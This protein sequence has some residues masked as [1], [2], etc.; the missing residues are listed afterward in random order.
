MAVEVL[1]L[2]LSGARV[3]APRRRAAAAPTGEGRA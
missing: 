2:F 3:R 1:R